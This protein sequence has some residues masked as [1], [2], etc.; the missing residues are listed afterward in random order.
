MAKG[1]K[2]EPISIPNETTGTNT[3][4]NIAIPICFNEEK[5]IKL[6]Y[7]IICVP[8]NNTAAGALEGPVKEPD[9]AGAGHCV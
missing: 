9:P 1:F 6:T 2:G 3:E 4:G 5:P 8:P 7:G